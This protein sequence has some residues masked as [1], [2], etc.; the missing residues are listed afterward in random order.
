MNEDRIVGYRLPYA[1]IA[2]YS[3]TTC[4]V[5]L[6]SSLNVWWSW[7]RSVYQFIVP[8]KASHYSLG[9]TLQWYHDTCVYTWGN[10]STI[11]I[12]FGNS[13]KILASQQFPKLKYKVQQQVQLGSQQTSGIRRVRILKYLSISSLRFYHFI[14]SEV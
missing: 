12:D 3:S 2:V 1:L 13:E 8:C 9:F 11:N 6:S 5:Y 14:Y 10:C 4:L 7:S